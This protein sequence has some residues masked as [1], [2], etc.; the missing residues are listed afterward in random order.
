MNN[1]LCNSCG[2]FIDGLC[3]TIMAQDAEIAEL[4]K[5]RDEFENE[6]FAVFYLAVE[7]WF[8]D[9]HGVKWAVKEGS[10][11]NESKEWKENWYEKRVSGTED[12]F[13]EKK[14]EKWGKEGAAEWLEKWK[15]DYDPN[16]AKCYHKFCEKTYKEGGWYHRG[17]RVDQDIKGEGQDGKTLWRYKVEWWQNDDYKVKDFEQ[18]E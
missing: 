1:K 7:K 15:E 16:S 5:Q 14:C 12:R 18:Y 6:L 13:I 17:Y 4:K 10:K 8:D 2:A 9:K 11:T 3:S